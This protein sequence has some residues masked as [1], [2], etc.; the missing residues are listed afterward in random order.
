MDGDKS[1]SNL[2]S[3]QSYR[4]TTSTRKRRLIVSSACSRGFHTSARL[5][6]ISPPA[7]ALSRT[8]FDHTCSLALRQRSEPLFRSRLAVVRCDGA[9][10]GI[11]WGE[12]S[13][14]AVNNP[15]GSFDDIAMLFSTIG[16]SGL[17]GTIRS[18]VGFLLSGGA[19]TPMRNK[20]S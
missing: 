6:F 3:T 8:G 17:A 13:D 4:N 11:T 1:G 10:D 9:E 12:S 18:G 2:R 20:N 14:F 15:D 5:A 16:L 19:A 7:I